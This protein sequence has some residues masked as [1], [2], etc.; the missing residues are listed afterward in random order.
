M[1]DTPAVAPVTPFDQ[2]QRYRLI[3]DLLCAVRGDGPPLFVLD[4][5]GRTGVLRNYLAPDDRVV[6]VDVER[7]EQSDL[8]MATGSALPFEDR[9]FDA[10]VAADTLEHVPVDGR[11]AFVLEACRVTKGVAIL[12]G[13]YFHPR[14]AE[15]EQRLAEFVCTR[16]GAP[17][18]YLEEHL[19]LGLPDRTKVEAWCKG[20]G[21]KDVRAL[22]HGNLERWLGLMSLALLL[23]DE[24][25][26]RDLAGRFH[27]FYNLALLPEDRSGRVYRHVV[28]AVMGDSLP[29]R[30][31]EVFAPRE[32]AEESSEPILNALDHLA[33]FDHSRDLF[34]AERARLEAEIHRRDEDLTGHQVSLVTAEEDLAQHKVS[35]SEAEALLDQHKRAL[36]V[37]VQDLKGHAG[38]LTRVRDELAA[39]Q[40][41]LVEAREALKAA[42]AE[43]AV[44]GEELEHARAEGRAVDRQLAEANE[45]I[46]QVHGK[47]MQVHGK[48]MQVL[49]ETRRY[50]KVR[51]FFW[52]RKPNE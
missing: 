32:L 7:S 37:A 14:V 29:E 20:A 1:I 19:E 12:A 16:I 46:Q 40:Q 26:T 52:R 30:V 8:V 25:A 50:R 41:G 44:R 13:P 4:V 23:D 17:H 24:A 18:R 10:V 22:G 42:Q 35:L 49:A 15:A 9:T 51:D 38:T 33:A 43:I 6:L 2:E 47:L 31:E 45:T 11:E 39:H 21:A 5:G 48:L 27:N 34:E 3:G 36:G 28:V